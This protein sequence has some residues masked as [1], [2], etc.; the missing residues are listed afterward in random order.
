VE[1]VEYNPFGG[2]FNTFSSTGSTRDKHLYQSKEWVTDFGV[3]FYDFEWRQYDP[4]TLRTTTMD[5]HG[6]KYH[7]LSPY[8]WAAN[9]PMT[10]VDPDGRDIVSSG[11]R[12]TYTGADASAFFRQIKPD[13]QR[14]LNQVSNHQTEL[15]FSSEFSKWRTERRKEEQKAQEGTTWYYMTRENGSP[16]GLAYDPSGGIIYEVNHPAQGHGLLHWLEGLLLNSVPNNGIKYDETKSVARQWNMRNANERAAFWEREKDSNFLLMPITV[17]DP[18]A[19]TA[20]FQSRQ[21]EA[22]DYNFFTNNCA[23]YSVQGLTAGGAAM[24]FTGPHPTMAGTYTLS[25][26]SG[27]APTPLAIPRVFALVPSGGH[28]VK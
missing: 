17:L 19:A 1:K 8:S 9:N 10:T 16:H 7:P 23:H 21:G 24:N 28:V 12:T 4:F 27:A 3:D 15:S 25:W 22:W 5:P 20:W 13:L 2:T 11:F 14:T 18:T 6:E 26:S